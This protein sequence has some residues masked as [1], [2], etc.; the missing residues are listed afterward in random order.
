MRLP[1]MTT[2]R[3]MVVVVV[4]AVALGGAL[5]VRRSEQLRSYYRSRAGITGWPTSHTTTCQTLTCNS[6]R[7][8][9]AQGTPRESGPLQQRDASEVRACRPLPLA[10][11]R[12]RPS[13]AEV[14]SLRAMGPAEML[15]D[16]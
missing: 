10:P 6:L 7:K 9:R 2:R 12:A 5:A 1:R 8:R 13:G 4:S 11:H 3:W 16:G 15:Q 14:T